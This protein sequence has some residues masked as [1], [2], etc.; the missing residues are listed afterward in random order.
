[1]TKLLLAIGIF[2]VLGAVDP[3]TCNE[4]RCDRVSV[5]TVN[6]LSYSPYSPYKASMDPCFLT[7][8]TLAAR[9]GLTSIPVRTALQLALFGLPVCRW[10]LV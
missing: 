4:R 7:R 1:M 5:S 6:A 3:I 9:A 8:A 10:F 2:T